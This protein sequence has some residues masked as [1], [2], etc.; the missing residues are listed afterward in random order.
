M[1]NLPP[2]LRESGGHREPYDL[3]L[4]GTDWF[5]SIIDRLRADPES[6]E[7]VI[8]GMSP[9]QLREFYYAYREATDELYGDFRDDERG[10]DDDDI[11]NAS[12]WVLNQGKEFYKAV[13]DDLSKY[14]DP[15][16]VEGVNYSALAAHISWARHRQELCG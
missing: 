15:T 12:C 2:W 4:Y 7:A 1:N 13:W 6:A 16:Q 11:H 8:G 5:W 10:W 3:G 14:P 9:E